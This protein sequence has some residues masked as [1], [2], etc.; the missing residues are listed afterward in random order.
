MEIRT[1]LP[2]EAQA[3]FGGMDD[4]RDLYL[5]QSRADVPPVFPPYRCVTSPRN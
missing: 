2:D 4:R 5:G 3:H 1:V